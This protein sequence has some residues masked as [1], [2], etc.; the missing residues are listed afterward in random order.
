MA[1]TA[2]RM[3]AVLGR[4]ISYHAQ[5]P[6]EARAGRNMS[7][8]IDHELARRSQTGNGVTETETRGMGLSLPPD[9]DR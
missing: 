2:E 3:S 5:T 6:H 1:E 4:K 7:R 9:R 8:M